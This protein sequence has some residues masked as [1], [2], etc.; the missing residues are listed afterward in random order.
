VRILPRYFVL[1]FL[2]SYA[3][4][5]FVSLVAIAIVEMMVNFDHVLEHGEGLAGVASYLF[6]RLPS[7]Y[8]PLLMPIAAFGAAFL[9]LGLPARSLEVLAAKASGIAPQRLAA[10]VLA[11]A[12]ALCLVSFAVSETLVLEASRRFER[13]EGDVNTERRLFQSR[14]SFWYHRGTTLLRVASADRKTRTLHGV[15]IWERDRNGRLLRSIRAESARIEAEQQWELRNAVIREFPPNRPEAAPRMVALPRTRLEIG[16]ADDLALLD[17]DPSSLSLRK[18]GEYI[19]AQD[20]D[21]RDTAPV[22]ALWHARLADPLSVLLFALLGAPLGAA[23][24]QTRS[25]AAP[26][27]RGVGLVGAFYALQ[28][29]VSLLGHG[30]AASAAPWLLLAGFGA[31]GLRRFAQMGT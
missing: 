4:I 6:L 17:A 26:A 3:A 1:G 15:Q 27:L 31:Y 23:V 24:E 16:S 28:T 19:D 9:G 20:R 22:R 11:A 5:L 8:L 7:Y 12:A 10:P 30:A 2:A 14:G 21:G 25:L 18:L 29:S 13:V